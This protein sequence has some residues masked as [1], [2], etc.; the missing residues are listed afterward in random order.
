MLCPWCMPDALHA[1][2]SRCYICH[3]ATTNSAVCKKDAY[4][5]KL[6]HVWVT[7]EYDEFVAKQ[8]IR[9]LKFERASGAAKAIAELLVDAL[10]Y[11]PK[12]TI[13]V[14]IPAATSRVRARGYDQSKLVAKQL[15]IALGCS[16]QTLL[17]RHGQARQVGAKR[18]ERLHQLVG[19]FRPNKAH[20]IKNAHILLVD[21]VLTTG[22]TIEEAA[23]VLK[24]AGAKTVDAA[25]FAQRQ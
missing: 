3:A 16:H 21:D 19:A 18:T 11:M 4:K 22:A 2:P 12:E 5:S 10:P 7:S 20:N 1:V 15:A 6:K 23:K 24:A 25:I 8:L 13:V 17:A 9:L 14:H